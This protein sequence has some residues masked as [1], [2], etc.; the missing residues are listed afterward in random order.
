MYGNNIKIEFIVNKINEM[1][2]MRVIEK[3]FS[4]KSAMDESQYEE[5]NEFA[6]MIISSLNN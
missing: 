5:I 1:K 3:I 2:N 6:E 4:V